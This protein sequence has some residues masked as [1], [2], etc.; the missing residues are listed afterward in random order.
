[1]VS[2]IH[3]DDYDDINAGSMLGGLLGM[4]D[5]MAKPPVPPLARDE[6]GGF[7]ISTVDTRDAGLETAVIGHDPDA[8]DIKTR[9]VER[10]SNEEDA[11]KGHAKWLE[12]ARTVG[13]MQVLDVGH[14]GMVGP[15]TYRIQPSVEFEGF[16]SPRDN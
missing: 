1:M 11:L 8:N 16:V 12:Q 9:I 15:E 7:M 13:F 5:A 2:R 3:D 10:Y 4:F 14:P 6:A